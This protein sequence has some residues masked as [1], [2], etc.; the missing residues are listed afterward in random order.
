MVADS[1]MI[2]GAAAVLAAYTRQTY[3]I[4]VI[5]LETTQ[6]INLFLPILLTIMISTS[7]GNLFNR[8]IYQQ[9]IELKQLPVLSDSVPFENTFVRA[10]EIM[11][12]NVV[13]VHAVTSVASL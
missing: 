13:Y 6:S 10:E 4:A 11:S 3:S 8:S 12:P 1:F 7:V 5:M 2:V 9:A